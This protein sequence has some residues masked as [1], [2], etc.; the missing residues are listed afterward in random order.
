MTYKVYIVLAPEP[1]SV[2]RA[3][4]PPGNFGWL[5]VKDT[6][7]DKNLAEDIIKAYEYRT[8]PVYRVGEHQRLATCFDALAN[9]ICAGSFRGWKAYLRQWKATYKWM[10]FYDRQN[11]GFQF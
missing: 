6:Q 5:E 7:A 9:H 10:V 1:Y 11:G 8:T 4:P 3:D 2:R